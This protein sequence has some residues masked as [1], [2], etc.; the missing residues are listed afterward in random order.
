M[1]ETGSAGTGSSSGS[2]D[3]GNPGSSPNLSSSTSSISSNGSGQGQ[4]SGTEAQKAQ[5]RIDLASIDPNSVVTLS[6]DGQMVEMSAKE[7][8]KRLGRAESANRKFQEAASM[9]Q[10]MTQL[11]QQINAN[12]GNPQALR[13]ILSQA[14]Y[15]PREIAKA[16]W[17]AEEYES[18]MTPEQRRIMQIEQ[19]NR[20]YKK[21]QEE[22]ARE[23]HEYAVEQ[24]ID[25]FRRDFN[26]A[27]TKAGVSN[28]AIRELIMPHLSRYTTHIK[29]NE[30]R[31]IKKSEAIT[32]V[33]HYM[34]QLGLSP[35]ARRAAITDDDYAAYISKKNAARP[36][37]MP[38]TRDP[39]GRFVAQS[40][41]PEQR[42]NVRLNANGQ[43]VVK[44]ISDL[45][46]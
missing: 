37:T 6:I 28:D 4:V 39:K 10:Q 43:Q 11:E 8:L 19:E 35:E 20:M 21:Q 16:M 7:A 22:Q 23:Q 44:R 33:K 36:Q 26:D 2:M 40:A 9:R 41:V 3:S 25:A 30:G 13:Y 15:S 1:S 27:M 38:S 46:K 31:I 24:Q 45:Y 12:L 34:E 18:N 42:P 17:D 14:G 29:L 5:A 32:F